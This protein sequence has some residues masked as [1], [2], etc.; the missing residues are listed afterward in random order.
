MD[1]TDDWFGLD[2]IDDV[3]IEALDRQLRTIGIERIRQSLH[4]LG[5]G[6][7][8]VLERD[9]ILLRKGIVREE[10]RTVRDRA[11]GEQRQPFTIAIDREYRD[12]LTR[13]HRECVSLRER[14]NAREHE[15]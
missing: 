6:L 8:A 10:Q 14:V 9:E 15:E 4:Q 12:V 2:W 11:I 3:R 1:W 13:Q 7:V 5:H